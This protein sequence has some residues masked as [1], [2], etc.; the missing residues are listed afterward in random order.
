MSHSNGKITA[1]VTFNDVNAVLGSSHNDLGSLCTDEHIKKW[2]KYKPVAL[3]SVDT[4]TGQ[5][6]KTN[7]KWLSSATWWKAGGNCGFTIETST[8]FGEPFGNTSTWSKK[9]VNGQ[10]GW[11]Y[12]KPY[13]AGTPNAYYRLQDFAGYNHQAI[14]PYGDIGATNIYIDNNGNAQ[15]DWE[16]VSVGDDNIKLTDIVL[17]KGSTDYPLTEFYLG[18]ILWSG[19]TYHLFTSS[20]KF[21]AGESLSIT[22]SNVSSLAGDWNCMPFFTLNQVNAQQTFD[23]NG[24]FASMA[25]V[26]PLSITLTTTGSV[27]IEMPDAMWNQN[28]TSVDYSFELVNTTGSAYNFSRIVVT[29]YGGSATGS[30]LGSITLTNQSVGA[31]NRK[32]LSGTVNASK[33]GYD[34]YWIVVSASS[35]TIESKYNQIEDYDAPID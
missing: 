14:K 27:Y 4:V 3:N 18:I 25:D 10:L 31:L 7:N 35:T 9:L 17:R 6:D 33:S 32:T 20:S 21:S 34:S 26:T 13:G 1:P 15:I 28:G 19:T 12:I 24:L 5:W 30:P 23:A 22:M 16:I 29:V 11:N 2:A 8:E